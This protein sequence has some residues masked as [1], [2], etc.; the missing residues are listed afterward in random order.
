M[1]KKGWEKC[2]LGDMLWDTKFQVIARREVILRKL[3]NN[4]PQIEVEHPSNYYSEEPLAYVNEE[5][6]MEVC[7]NNPGKLTEDD[8]IF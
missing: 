5:Q 8:E 2:G 3:L 1:I 6:A 7:L 4:L